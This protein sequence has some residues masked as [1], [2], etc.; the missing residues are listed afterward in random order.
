MEVL[1][2]YMKFWT[3]HYNNK[4]CPKFMY[5]NRTFYSPLVFFFFFKVLPAILLKI[6][7]A[8]EMGGI[9]PR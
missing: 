9:A 2:L 8:T 6:M 4:M 7:S 5:K 1:F 3:N